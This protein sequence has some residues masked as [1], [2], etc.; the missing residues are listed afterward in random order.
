MYTSLQGFTYQQA[1]IVG[2]QVLRT[3]TSRP[4]AMILWEF[5]NHISLRGHRI[6][7]SSWGFPPC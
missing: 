6:P 5:S 7:P 3:G 1:L 4:G 2:F